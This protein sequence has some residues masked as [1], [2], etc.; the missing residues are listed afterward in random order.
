MWISK[1]WDHRPYNCFICCGLRGEEM[2][3]RLKY[4]GVPIEKIIVDADVTRAIK[5]TLAGGAGS[6][7]LFSTYTALWPIQRIIKTLALEGGAAR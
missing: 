6:A 3:V 2:A 7:Y 5:S 1:C 4:A